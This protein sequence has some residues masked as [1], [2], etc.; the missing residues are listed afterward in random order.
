[1]INVSLENK[2][3]LW[4]FMKPYKRV[5]RELVPQNGRVYQYLCTSKTTTCIFH[6]PI[7]KNCKL[8]LDHWLFELS[9][10][11]YVLEWVIESSNISP[12]N[13]YKYCVKNLDNQNKLGK[14]RPIFNSVLYCLNLNILFPNCN[15]SEVTY[16]F[17]IYQGI[18]TRINPQ[19]IKEN[20]GKV[21]R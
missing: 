19:F 1:M 12:D 9:T 2:I 21:L 6:S 15:V 13:F 4:R 14:V 5:L 18:A 7:S 10:T 8:P 20:L 11:K 3:F 16:N 17:I